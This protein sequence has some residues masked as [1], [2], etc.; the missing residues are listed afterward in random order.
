MKDKIHWNSLRLHLNLEFYAHKSRVFSK[1]RISLSKITRFLVPRVRNNYKGNKVQW[2]FELHRRNLI[3]VSSIMLP[4]SRVHYSST[5]YPRNARV[6]MR[7]SVEIKSRAISK[8]L[9]S[10]NVPS[11]W[12]NF[13]NAGHRGR[14]LSSF[15]KLG[16][17]RIPP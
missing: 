8:R 10:N 7:R 3:S 16:E 6:E 13:R 5:G 11:L 1:F 15:L 17:R 12:K 2:N 4:P 14:K 9:I